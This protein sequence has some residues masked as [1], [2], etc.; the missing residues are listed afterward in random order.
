MTKADL[1]DV[2]VMFSRIAAMS[3]EELTTFQ[4]EMNKSHAWCM[5]I[6]EHTFHCA[7]RKIVANL[8]ERKLKAV[9]AKLDSD[10]PMTMKDHGR[11][12]SINSELSRRKEDLRDKCRGSIEPYN[13]GGD[14]DQQKC[15]AELFSLMKAELDWLGYHG[16]VKE[17]D[18]A[19]VEHVFSALEAGEL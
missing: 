8:I 4:K 7:V 19:P 1:D 9:G 15:I 18:N 2:R 10:V 11:I 3:I 16:A 17:I 6:E 12:H 14:G 13:V 5:D